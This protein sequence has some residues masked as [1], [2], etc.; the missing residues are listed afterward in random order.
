MKY[1]AIEDHVENGMYCIGIFNDHRTAVGAIVSNLW[2]FQKSY[3][4]PGDCFSYSTLEPM[5]GYGGEMMKVTFKAACWEQPKEH[6]YFVLYA[7]EDG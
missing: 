2:E 3:K 1:I 5:E 6:N 7:E 4:K